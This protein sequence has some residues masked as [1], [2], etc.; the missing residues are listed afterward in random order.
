MCTLGAGAA[1][2]EDRFAGDAHR[3]VLEAAGRWRM[4]ER[5]DLPGV[6]A[7]GEIRALR[8]GRGEVGVTGEVGIRRGVAAGEQAGEKTGETERG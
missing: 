6:D 4:M 3:S 2:R 7:C 1:G 8:G 5:G